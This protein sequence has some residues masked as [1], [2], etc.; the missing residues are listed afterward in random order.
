MAN[1]NRRGVNAENVNP[2]VGAGGG[3]FTGRGLNG[4]APR[5]K[6]TTQAPKGRIMA[7]RAPLASLSDITNIQD[8]RDMRKKPL[9][10]PS[11]GFPERRETLAQPLAPSLP[12]PPSQ[13][14]PMEICNAD[15]AEAHDKVQSVAEYAPEII[16]QL[17]HDEGL[18]MPRVNYME[19]Q[20][21]INGKMRAILVDW[22]VEVHM[23]YR[24]RSET[25][26]L[27]V[28]L[29]DRYLS[30]LPVLRRRLQLLGVVAMF[31]ASKF[32]EIDPPRATDFVYITDNTYSKD[33]LLQMECNMLSTL[34]FQVVV[35]TAAHFLN[36]FI[37]ANGCENP[38][39][40]EVIK[41]IVELALID[42]RMIRYKPSHLVASAVLLSNELFGRSMPWPESMV[43]ISRHTDA[44]LRGCCEEM[45]QLVRQANGQQLQAVRKKYMLAQHYQVARNAVLAGA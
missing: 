5:R 25:L 18:Y 1:F 14:I 39:H 20:Q 10:E 24:L 33:E 13:A 21:D 15:I 34:E 44:E 7:G 26:F 12:V 6:V 36:P 3:V 43:Q 37:K 41:Y 42:L 35:P 40:A 29:I 11:L 38:R 32:E 31:V 9:R 4:A 22:L 8:A 16:D 30:V 45:R 17:F 2:N 28:N 19:S 27:A 23:K